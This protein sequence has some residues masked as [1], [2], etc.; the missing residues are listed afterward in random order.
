MVVPVNLSPLY[1][2]PTDI[3]VLSI[4]YGL[5]LVLVMGITAACISVAKRQKLWLA[6]WC[7][8]VITLL[9]VLGIAAQVGIQLMADRYTYLPSIGPFIVIA[10]GMAWVSARMRAGMQRLPS[11]LIL[12]ASALIIFVALSFLTIRQTAIWKSGITLWSRVIEQEPRRAPIAYVNRGSVLFKEEGNL[13]GALADFTKAI[14]LRPEEVG[15]YLNPF[16]YPEAHYYRGQVFERMWQ[17]EKA[18][19]DFDRA[20]ALKPSYYDAYVSS[21]ILYGKSGS[22]DRALEQFNKAIEINPDGA[23]AYA[24]RGYAHSLMG[25]Y[26]RALEDLTRAIAL[27]QQ[28]P[29]NYVNRGK[30]FLGTGNREQAVLDFR[31]ACD[32]GD[33]EGCS[34]L[35]VMQ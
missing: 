26:D 20:I 19:A 33:E 5:P 32:S 11:G 1:P 24:N 8:Y 25:N 34:I 15:T 4:G 13:E 22:L 3:S 30:V 21:G 7:Y 9:P 10:S 35:S 29:K 28:N 23:S 6:A 31:R 27:D 18:L 14:A 16:Y 2:Y 12:T 17:F